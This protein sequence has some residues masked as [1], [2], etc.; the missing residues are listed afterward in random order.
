MEHDWKPDFKSYLKWAWGLMPRNHEAN[1]AVRMGK[2]AKR[3]EAKC[4][5]LQKVADDLAVSVQIKTRAHEILC[6][7]L[8]CKALEAYRQMEAK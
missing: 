3:L 8:S 2:Y 4:G 5:K 7:C 1:E 6:S